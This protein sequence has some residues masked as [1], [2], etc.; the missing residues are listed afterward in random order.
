MPVK[1]QSKRA[2]EMF[3]YKEDLFETLRE[4]NIKK[5]VFAKKI[6]LTPQEFANILGGWCLSLPAKKIYSID[7]F[8]DIVK[9]AL[10]QI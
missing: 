4:K 2:A 3:K 1:D 10:C 8:K 7:Q 6:N 5:S 9:D